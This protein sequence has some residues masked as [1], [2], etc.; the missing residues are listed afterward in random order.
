MSTSILYLLRCV[1][2]KLIVTKPATSK[3]GNSELYV[4]GIG[5]RG[6]KEEYISRMLEFAGNKLPQD[7][8]FIHRDSIPEV[9]LEE[10]VKC[11]ELFTKLQ[12][13]TI[14][15]NLRLFMK[16][17]QDEKRDIVRDSWRV[18]EEFVRRYDVSY[19]PQSQYIASDTNN[20]R[21]T[22][23]NKRKPGG[24]L[25]ER[26]EH[27][28][29]AE[30]PK[31]QHKVEFSGVVRKQMESMGWEEGKS[32]GPENSGI[33][34]PIIPTKLERGR[35]LGFGEEMDASVPDLKE[36][37]KQEDPVP[38]VPVEQVQLVNSAVEPAVE[39]SDRS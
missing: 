14:E 15:R 25:Q 18:A 34:E 35:G 10:V 27:Q 19:I 38:V 9:F 1:F 37:I 26:R 33:L 6:L 11:V 2:E 4:V 24:N 5:F 21:S 3:A 20:R 31:K 8:C 22:G 32:L 29:T 17:S 23:S 16:M 39:D 28:Q 12:V 36:E 13:A 30:P 7:L